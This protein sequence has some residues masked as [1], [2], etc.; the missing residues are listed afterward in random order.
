MMTPPMNLNVAPPPPSGAES[1]T[2]TLNCPWNPPKMWRVTVMARVRPP[3][4]RMRRA[5]PCCWMVV[6]SPSTQ[7]THTCWS[8]RGAS[9]LRQNAQHVL[10]PVLVVGALATSRPPS[11]WTSRS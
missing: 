11:S 2:W 7:V 10:P 9:A 5:T 1:I 3:S 4:F 8:R 6:M